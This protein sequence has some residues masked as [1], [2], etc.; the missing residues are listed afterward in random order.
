MKNLH[1]WDAY[2]VDR[3]ASEKLKTAQRKFTTYE[4]GE[5][6][7][8]THQQFHYVPTITDLVIPRFIYL[9][10]KDFNAIG[11]YRNMSFLKK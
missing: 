10:I 1:D 3:M 6:L 2:Y 9:G 4:L 8:K 7:E 5:G 11:E